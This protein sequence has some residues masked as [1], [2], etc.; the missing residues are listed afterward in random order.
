MSWWHEYQVNVPEGESGRFRVERFEV[1]DEDAARERLRAV[2]NS[3]SRRMPVPAGQYT[4][5]IRFPVDSRLLAS[6]TLVMSDTPAEIRDH[7]YAVSLAHG[8]VLVNGLGLGVVVQAMLRKPEVECLTVVEI[9]PDVISLVGPYY[10]EMFG[11]RLEIIEA[12]ALEWKAPVG[13]RFDVVWHD[14][15]DSVNMDNLPD[16][17]KLHRKYGHRCGYQDSWARA[18]C[19]WQRDF[20]EWSRTYGG[21]Y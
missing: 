17:H 5:L 15:W 21:R 19:E 1:S 14:I 8:R 7:M 6:F 13:D 12:D 16:M 4:R 20:L 3:F 11:D 10:Q 18:E 9:E 2:I